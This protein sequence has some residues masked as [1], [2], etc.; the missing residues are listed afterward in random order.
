M[1]PRSETE[2]VTGLYAVH[3]G[4]EYSVGSY[5]G[6]R[7]RGYAMLRIDRSQVD[8]FTE[9]RSDPHLVAKVRL[10]D[11]DAFVQVSRRARYAGR[12][13]S[14]MSIDESEVCF[15]ADAPGWWGR[16]HRLQGSQLNGFYGCRRRDEV[17]L[18][19]E[20]VIDLL[21]AEIGRPSRGWPGPSAVT[22]DD[23]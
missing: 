7:G 13:V 15:S 10:E 17:E 19:D 22:G 12:D 1:S 8:R 21:G 11:L 18:L 3:R 6:G 20:E 14:V 16:E 9:T 2:H 5:L 4:E 23:E